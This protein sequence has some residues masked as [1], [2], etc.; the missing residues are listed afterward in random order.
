MTHYDSLFSIGALLLI[1]GCCYFQKKKQAENDPNT[2]KVKTNVP[3]VMQGEESQNLI[4]G[5]IDDTK[6]SDEPDKLPAPPLKPKMSP[7]SSK[8]V[9]L[10]T[11]DPEYESPPPDEPEVQ[12]EVRVTQL[13]QI[14]AEQT[15]H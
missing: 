1:G 4:N 10:T 11:S 13:A 12:P 14:T 9:P 15:S 5:G 7:D 2:S 3:I 6:Y 8:S